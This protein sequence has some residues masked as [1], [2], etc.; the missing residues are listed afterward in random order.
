MVH[1]TDLLVLNKIMN[2]LTLSSQ[3]IK[4][5]MFRG[6]RIESKP[7]TIKQLNYALALNRSPDRYVEIKKENGNTK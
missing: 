6:K 5:Y 2:D 7:D 3:E 1:E 4:S